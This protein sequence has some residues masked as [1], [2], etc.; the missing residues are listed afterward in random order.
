MSEQ[1]NSIKADEKESA[2]SGL[3]LSVEPLSG[4]E[5]YLA[6][7]ADNTDTDTDLADKSDAT[8]ADGTDESD[9]DGTD[10]DDVDGDGSD[11]ITIDTDG[12]DASGDSD[13]TDD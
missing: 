2:R 10:D 3:L 11:A 9:A 1:D 5:K 13:G 4:S 8:D 12:R 7:Q 6:T